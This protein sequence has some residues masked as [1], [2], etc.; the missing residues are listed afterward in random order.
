M[1]APAIQAPPESVT[2]R[3]EGQQS[4]A[5]R[6]D[7]KLDPSH[8]LDLKLKGLSDTEI[9]SITGVSIRRVG[10]VLAT[11]KPLIRAHQAGVKLFAVNPKAEDELLDAARALILQNI[12]NPKT[13]EGATLR[14]SALAYDKLHLAKRLRSGE[15]TSNSELHVHV[16]GAMS[17]ALD[18]ASKR[19]KVDSSPDRLLSSNRTVEAQATPL[20]SAPP[21]AELEAPR[22]SARL[23]AGGG[24]PPALD[25][26]PAGRSKRVAGA[27]F[28]EAWAMATAPVLRGRPRGRK[29]AAR[30]KPLRKRRAK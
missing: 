29:S 25:A 20:E 26:S 18:G 16:Q 5:V 3:P 14:D 19:G 2:G 6:A 7:A 27:S 9:A 13:Y 21:L 1:G 30:R 17:G 28:A 12:T 4:H 11:M 8:A 10:Q 22:H 15:S 23:P 24:K